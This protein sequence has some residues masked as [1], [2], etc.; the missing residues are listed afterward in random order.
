MK[1]NQFNLGEKYIETPSMMIK[2]NIMTWG[3]TMIQL[4]NISYISAENIETT[5][6]PLLAALLAIVGLL[7]MGE[8]FL[9]GFILIAAGAIWI[10]YWY[11]ENEKRK[12]GAILTIRMNSGHNLYFTFTNK[13]FLLKVLGVLERIIIDGNVSGPVSIDIKGCTITGSQLFTG[14]NT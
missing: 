6:F 9:L 13:Q 14:I 12:Q 8:A 4:S 11:K 3:N 1:P 2:K 7:L 5:A 10:Y